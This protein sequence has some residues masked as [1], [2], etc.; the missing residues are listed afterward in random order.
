MRLYLL[1]F[2]KQTC[3][4]LRETDKDSGLHLMRP[5]GQNVVFDPRQWIINLALYLDFLPL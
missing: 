5:E 2:I 4:T 1:G 3:T